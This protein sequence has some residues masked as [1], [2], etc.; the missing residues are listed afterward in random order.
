LY[1]QDDPGN[2]R[3]G[4]WRRL[5]ELDRSSVTQPYVAVADGL[6]ASYQLVVQA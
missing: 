3:D 4:I 1:V 2:A 5:N 6:K